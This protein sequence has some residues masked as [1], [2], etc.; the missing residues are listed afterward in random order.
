MKGGGVYDEVDTV[1]YTEDT[2]SSEAQHRYVRFGPIYDKVDT[3]DYR[4]VRFVTK[5]GQIGPK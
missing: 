4:E 1:D 2:V 5:V 3:V